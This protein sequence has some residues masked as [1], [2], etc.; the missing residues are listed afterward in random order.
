MTKRNF[1]LSPRRQ[2][3][4]PLVVLDGGVFDLSRGENGIYTLLLNTPGPVNTIQPAALHDLNRILD[5]ISEDRDCRG[6]I[7][8]TPFDK[9]GIAGADIKEIHRLQSDPDVNAFVKVTEEAKRIL[10]RLSKMPFP[11]VAAINGAWRGGGFEM[12]LFCNHIL[13]IRGEEQKSVVQLPECMIGLIPGF[14]GCVHVAQRMARLTDAV[15][16]VA[17]FKSLK[18][19]EAHEMGLIDGLCD[20]Y[21]Q[22]LASAERYCLM[23]DT[24][25]KILKNSLQVQTKW[26]R[27]LRT[28]GELK[29]LFG[30]KR[31]KVLM[32]VVA[33]SVLENFASTL[34]GV[35]VFYEVLATIVGGPNAYGWL[36]TMLVGPNAFVTALLALVIAIGASFDV[37]MRQWLAQMIVLQVKGKTNLTGPVSA[38]SLIMQVRDISEAEASGLESQLFAQEARSPF[39]RGLVELF[40]RKG[41]ARDAFSAVAAPEVKKLGIVGAG[42]PMGAGIAALAAAVES[43]ES[44]VLIDVKPEALSGAMARIEKHL[45]KS[46]LGADQKAAALG[47]IVCAL[48]YAA[49]ADCDAIIEAVPEVEAMKRAAYAQIASVMSARSE[50]KPW[51]LLT[52]TSALDLDSLSSEL[53]EQAQRF[54]GLHFFN[55]PEQ[56]NVVEVGCAAATSDETM[57]V[58]VRLVAAMNKAPLPVFNHRGFLLNRQLGPYLVMLSHLLAEGVPPEDIDKAIKHS[59]APMGPSVLLDKVGADIVASVARTLQAV[60]GDRVALPADERNVLK[61][62]LELGDLGEKTGRGIYLWENGKPARDK[63]GK[64]VINPALKAAFPGLGENK[65]YSVEAI[66]TLLLGAIANEAVR[67]IEENV[68]APEHRIYGDAAFV[69]GTGLTGVWGGPIGYLNAQGVVVFTRLSRIIAS[70][71]PET[72][73]KNFQPCDLLLQHECSG[74][75][76]RL[77]STAALVKQAA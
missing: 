24:S 56:M 8:S 68:V 2:E 42:G 77:E 10:G 30:R 22:M 67:V 48:D 59:G 12:A 60:L 51:F 65:S 75:D 17:G 44:L 21:D 16:F 1:G 6:L 57:A 71:G 36:A 70:A 29:G 61:I 9:P 19:P 35:G 41:G 14:M 3:V 7:I 20:S 26:R 15:E 63:K 47:K 49:L 69:L 32:E 34:I 31:G 46:K 38:A 25:R 28:I 13:G 11:T 64:L 52:N 37:S 45:G 5:V 50:Q 53:G 23:S 18:A 66:Q 39:G 58:G 62:L 33:P 72:W 73:R 54:A 27:A 76:I 4:A 55:P 43:I 40:V 74:E